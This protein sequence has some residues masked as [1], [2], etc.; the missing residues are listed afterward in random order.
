MWY[1]I[2]RYILY[3]IIIKISKSEI[4]N[5]LGE[6]IKTSLAYFYMSEICKKFT[7]KYKI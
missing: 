7:I 5:K 1:R 3:K 6:E 4:K 2:F